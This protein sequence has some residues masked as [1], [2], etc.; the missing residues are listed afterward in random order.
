ML[1]ISIAN[2]SRN[3]TICSFNALR[4]LTVKLVSVLNC[5]C[6][7]AIARA[8]AA[9]VCACLCLYASWIKAIRASSA[10]RNISVSAFAASRFSCKRWAAC[11]FLSASK[12]APSVNRLTAIST[13]FPVLSICPCIASIASSTLTLSIFPSKS[14]SIFIV[15]S[16]WA[17][18]LFTWTNISC[19]CF[20]FARF[21]SKLSISS[22]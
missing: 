16:P 19:N 21:A 8:L 13:D 15:L 20:N 14:T 5:N 9:C 3:K 7:S 22:P 4:A 6:I 2:C 18:A 11:I 10:L 12:S 17:L 1:A